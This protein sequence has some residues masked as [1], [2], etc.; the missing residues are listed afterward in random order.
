MATSAQLKQG[1]M[2]LQRG[3][4]LPAAAAECSATVTHSRISYP[5]RVLPLRPQIL[6]HSTPTKIRYEIAECG[7]RAQ[8][9][10]CVQSCWMPRAPIGGHPTKGGVPTIKTRPSESDERPRSVSAASNGIFGPPFLYDPAEF[11]ISF[12]WKWQGTVLPLVFS[13]PLFWFLMLAHA[14]CLA[15]YHYL[16]G[17]EPFLDWKAALVPSS[18]LTFLLVSFGNQCYDRYFHLYTHSVGLHG[19]VMEWSALI[20]LEFGHKGIDFQWNTLRLL[21]GAMQVH[22]ALLGGDDVSTDGVRVKG[23][24]EDE[25]RAIRTRNLLSRDEISRLKKYCGFKPFL[26]VG[27]A[28]AEVK[29]GLLGTDATAAMHTNLDDVCGRA[30]FGAFLDVAFK[31]RAHSS[32]T[33][34]LLNAPVPF[35]YFHV[36]K[37][38]LLLSLLII[39]YA[40]V[41]L[42]EGQV[43]ATLAQCAVTGESLAVAHPL[44]PGPSLHDCGRL[45]SH[46]L[47]RLL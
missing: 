19:S 10:R 39:N 6:G 17:Q 40:L 38:L 45:A 29:G 14:I 43:C 23:I 5:L 28:L 35:A 47:C 3:E 2:A 26:P 32:N 4:T 24:S 41:E 42:L 46:R 20:K 27:W 15:A 30:V 36:M 7:V 21:L 25:W 44:S 22:Y 9:A 33:F 16:D 34:N 11:G 1:Y 31:F 12:L 37:L 8:L 13:S 18:L